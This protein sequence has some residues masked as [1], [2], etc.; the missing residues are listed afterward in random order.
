MVTQWVRRLERNRPTH[1]PGHTDPRS[2][3]AVSNILNKFDYSIN[4]TRR[5]ELFES[6]LF[7]FLKPASMYPNG[8][9]FL[10]LLNDRDQHDAIQKRGRFCG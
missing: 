7:V 6:L 4:G 3:S 2:R 8:A 9:G 1:N 10:R 5:N